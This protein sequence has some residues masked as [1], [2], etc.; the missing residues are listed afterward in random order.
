MPV[1][2]EEWRAGIVNNKFNFIF[3]VK[4][5]HQGSLIDL[6]LAMAGP[7]VSIYSYMYFLLDTGPL[8][9]VSSK[10]IQAKF[11]ELW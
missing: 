10:A 1:G 8:G 6:C 9:P 11:R 5:P 3:H 2:L 4:N 7:I